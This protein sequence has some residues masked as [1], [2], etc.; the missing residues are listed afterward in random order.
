MFGLISSKF[1]T[2]VNFRFDPTLSEDFYFKVDATKQIAEFTFTF[3][4][5]GVAPNKNC[6]NCAEKYMSGD[7]CVASCSLSQ[8]EV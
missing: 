8:Y 5:I 1:D 3:F 7:E 6:E 4:A 2:S